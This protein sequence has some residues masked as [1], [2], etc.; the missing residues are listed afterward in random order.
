MTKEWVAK[1]YS[2]LTD[3]FSCSLQMVL[4]VFRRLVCWCRQSSN[5][6][7]YV[8]IDMEEWVYSSKSCR[9]P[10]SNQLVSSC[11][12]TCPFFYEVTSFCLEAEH[13]CC[14][15]QCIFASF[16]WWYVTSRGII[17]LMFIELLFGD[18]LVNRACFIADGCGREAW[19]S[20]INASI[21]MLW[22]EFESLMYSP[23]KVFIR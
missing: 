23:M 2:I 16:G 7:W 1:N 15:I 3:N 20:K 19:R 5:T 14:F 13:C 11:S 17:S 10:L 8:W 21:I 9:V 4:S 22:F 12:W 18:D 6:W